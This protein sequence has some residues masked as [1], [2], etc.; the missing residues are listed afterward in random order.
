MKRK[1][2][3]LHLEALQPRH[4]MTVESL[5]WDGASSLRLSFV[6]DGTRVANQVSDANA[7]LS[8]SAAGANWKESV[9]KAF[10]VWAQYAAINVGVVGD[11]GDPMGVAGP[12]HGDERFGEIRVAG[13]PMTSDT[14]AAAVGMTSI[15][16][17]LG[18][19]IYSS[20]PMPIGQAVRTICS[21][22]RCMRLGTFLGYLTMTTRIH[23]CMHMAFL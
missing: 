22:R 13:I 10:Q 3:T 1:K 7:V 5:A 6:P 9:A 8:Q 11:S 16:Q 17:A 14:W 15:R 19:A 20:I 21:K 18:R 4:L 23:R 12:V 2:R